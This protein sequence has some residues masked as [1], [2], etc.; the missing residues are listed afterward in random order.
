[1]VHHMPTPHAVCGVVNGGVCRAGLLWAV[2]L[3]VR[4]LKGPLRQSAHEFVIELIFGPLF[5]GSLVPGKG[6]LLLI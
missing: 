6:N 2:G 5:P 3:A 4:F 1:M